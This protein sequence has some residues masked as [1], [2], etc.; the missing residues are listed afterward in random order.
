[1]T[2]FHDGLEVERESFGRPL[3]RIRHGKRFESFSNSTFGFRGAGGVPS[4][5]YILHRL[6][7]GGDFHVGPYVRTFVQ[8]GD[9]LEAGRLPGPQ[10]T[11]INRGDLAQGFVE[12]NLPAG[13]RSTMNARVGRQEMTF[14]S[15]RLVDIREGPNIRQSFDGARVW[16]TQVAPVIEDDGNF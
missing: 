3:W 9:E 8:I 5:N 7:L 4:E 10:P 11:D 12:L 14:G 15:G 2:G 16:T 6:L 1:V 13:E